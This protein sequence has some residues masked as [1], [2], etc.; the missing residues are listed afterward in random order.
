MS[1]TTAQTTYE[2]LR[3]GL[4]QMNFDDTRAMGVFL[5]EVVEREGDFWAADLIKARYLNLRGM[6]RFVTVNFS[7][8][9]FSKKVIVASIGRSRREYFVRQLSQSI[10]DLHDA[11]EILEELEDVDPVEARN[12]RV[13][14]DA[15]TR[16]LS[17]VSAIQSAPE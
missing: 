9:L 6:I 7:P 15:V 11:L 14:E 1:A 8:E 12:T 16:L 4:K 3:D 2:A 17:Q 10:E 13:A 5:A